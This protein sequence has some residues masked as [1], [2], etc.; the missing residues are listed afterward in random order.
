MQTAKK[1]QVAHAVGALIL[2]LGTTQ[3]LATGFNPFSFQFATPAGASI[4]PRLLQATRTRLWPGRPGQRLP[5]RARMQHGPQAQKAIE[6]GK[7]RQPDN[8]I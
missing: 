7:Q 4:P 1:K 2:G 6:Q 3:A 5:A 8:R